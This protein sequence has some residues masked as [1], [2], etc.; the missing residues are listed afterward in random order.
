ML[1]NHTSITLW[2]YYY[3]MNKLTRDR[4]PDKK[5]MFICVPVMPISS[6]N[7]MFDHMLESSRWDDSN[8]WS[9]IGF[10]EEM[11]IIEKYAPYLEPCFVAPQ[12]SHLTTFLIYQ[13][14]AEILNFWIYIHSY[15]FRVPNSVTF[16]LGRGSGKHL[17]PLWI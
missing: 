17:K 7:P 8:K 2:L 9:N 12:G 16:V 5:H 13:Q 15:C 14:T 4:V 1:Y 10:G 3:A 11:V 6:P